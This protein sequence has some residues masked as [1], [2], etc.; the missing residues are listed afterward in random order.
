MCEKHNRAVA[1]AHG[2]CVPL[3]SGR[4]DECNLL[5]GIEK[6]PEETDE[7]SE[8]DTE[9][10]EE[11]T[12]YQVTPLAEIISLLEKVHARDALVEDGPQDGWFRGGIMEKLSS[13]MK[14][15]HSRDCYKVCVEAQTVRCN[16]GKPLLFVWDMVTP[17]APFDSMKYVIDAARP[18]LEDCKNFEAKY[19]IPRRISF[20]PRDMRP[21]MAM[22][23]F[24]GVY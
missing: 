7:D 21:P 4:R 5:W 15:S 3:A 17:E 12:N 8:E 2:A 24:A 19:G 16:A 20:A 9:E 6:A 22:D 23:L 14:K 10:E 11:E 18:P 13:H 1:D